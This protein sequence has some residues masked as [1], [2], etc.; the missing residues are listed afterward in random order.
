MG[1]LPEDGIARESAR[2]PADVYIP[3]WN[4][5]IP[6]CLDF[7]VTSGMR[8]GAGI[9]TRSAMDNKAA[10][11]DYEDF[12]CSHLETKRHCDREGLTFI[13]MIVEAVGGSWGPQAQKVW[14]E[15]AKSTALA[16]GERQDIIVQ[17]IYQGMGLIL[18]RENARAITRRGTATTSGD[19]HILSAAATLA[20]DS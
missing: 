7:A 19:H 1:P 14:C 5:G 6:A 10:L 2:R 3:R 8:E 9:L 15:F 16:T 18:H 17:R 20:S 12:K 4:R 13:P 11:I